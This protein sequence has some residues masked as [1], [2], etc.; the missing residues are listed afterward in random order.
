[1][2]VHGGESGDLAGGALLNVA[3]GKDKDGKKTPGSAKAAKTPTPAAGAGASPGNA[4]GTLS[5]LSSSALHGGAEFVVPPWDRSMATLRALVLQLETPPGTAATGTAT[6]GTATPDDAAVTAL[7]LEYTR[8]ANQMSVLPPPLPRVSPHELCRELVVQLVE[9]V[10]GVAA[11]AQVAAGVP[12]G[13]FTVLEPPPPFVPIPDSKM[14]PKKGG[15]A[16]AKDK[17][18]PPAAAGAVGAGAGK[19]PMPPKSAAGKR[20]FFLFGSLAASV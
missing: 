2:K 19:T 4:S 9:A 6:T 5:A 11:E 16:S 10:A 15:R 3:G 1:M 8:L 13:P 17:K 20:T 7:Q 12:L 14:D 18:P